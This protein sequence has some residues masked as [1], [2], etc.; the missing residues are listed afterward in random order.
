[1]RKLVNWRKGQPV[2]HSG[3][4]MHFGAEDDTY[5]YFRYDGRKKVMVAFN[6]GAK[7][8]VLPSARFREMLAGVRSGVDVLTGKTFALDT[9]LTL[10]ARSVVV[11]ELNMKAALTLA[12]ALAAPLACAA[13]DPASTPSS[14]RWPSRSRPASKSS[15][16]W[17][18]MW[19]AI[20]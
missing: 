17:A 8:A 19:P 13:Q 5:V 7:Q 16:S 15:S 3:K 1:V 2:I 11:L 20:L 10:P 6:K 9:A 18:T 12:A 14:T 4:M